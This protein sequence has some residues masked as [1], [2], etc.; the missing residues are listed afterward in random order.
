VDTRNVLV[1]LAAV[2]GILATVPMS[3]PTKEK[4]R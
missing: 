4:A 1:L 2:A 3:M